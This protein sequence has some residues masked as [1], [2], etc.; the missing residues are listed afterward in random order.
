MM[1]KT[2]FTALA[3]ATALT[4]VGGAATAQP[5]GGA[6]R[7]DRDGRYEQRWER[8][9][10]NQRQAHIDRMID[11]G[12]RRG[13]LT[14]QEASRLHDQARDIARLEARY[15]YN[16]LTSWERSDLDRRLDGLESRLSRELRDR[17]YGYGYGYRR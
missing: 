15:R 4:A 11:V 14:R 5:Y 2:L 8:N 12:F 3:A 10:I 9:H 6:D 16:G 13:D 7:Y 1:K 17:Q